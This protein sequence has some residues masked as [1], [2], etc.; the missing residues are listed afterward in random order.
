MCKPLCDIGVRT[1]ESFTRRGGV[2]GKTAEVEA[3]A[4]SGVVGLSALFNAKEGGWEDEE[5]FDR[6]RGVGERGR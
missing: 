3:L 5:V 4:L 1:E 6:D 2:E